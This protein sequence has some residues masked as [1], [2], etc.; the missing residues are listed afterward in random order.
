MNNTIIDQ[1]L[2]LNPEA[3]TADGYDRSIKGIGNRDGKPV[4]LYSSD[5]CI[6]QLMED[7]DW[8]YD[9]ALDWFCYNTLGA[10]AGESTP[11][12][13][14]EDEEQPSTLNDYFGSC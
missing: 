7:N 5:K 4:L 6:Q 2:E 14:W 12:F 1:I 8:T 11:L 9:D 3:L 10:Y 13:E